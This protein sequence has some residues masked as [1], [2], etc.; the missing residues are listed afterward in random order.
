MKFLITTR[1]E[2]QS[3][4][5]AS[6]ALALDTLKPYLRHSLAEREV[7]K[8]LTD[9]LY[10]QLLNAYHDGSLNDVDKEHLKDLLPLVQKPLAN[11]AMYYYLQEG[12]VTISDA[13]VET[14]RDKTA[15]AW[16]AE[17]IERAY[18]ENAYFGLDNLISY[19][20]ANA[21]AFSSWAASSAYA[22][23]TQ[24]LVRNAATF[25]QSVNIGSSHRTFL[26]LQPI[27]KHVEQGP[28][29]SLLGDE[30]FEELLT[31][32]QDDDLSPEQKRLL[33]KLQAAICYLTMA[34]A[35]TDLNIEVT[36]DGAF[37]QSFK[38]TTQSVKERHP[39]RENDLDRYRLQMQKRGAE[40]L[41]RCRQY[42]NTKASP[43]VFATF[44]AS[45]YYEDPDESTATYEQDDNGNIYNAL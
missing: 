4:T 39:A 2:L 30:F 17:K 42:L 5:G 22:D 19:L 32:Y 12:S 38:A 23:A 8:V 25:Q 41:E 11:L 44:Y 35:I 9:E 16:Q 29:Q 31:A 6:A 13:G 40:W 20:L 18:L 37:Q 34:E 15:F 43:T 45:A 26:A 33:E 27:L 21:D 28:I 36:A 3:F 1:E 14:D 24:H 7:L 10:N